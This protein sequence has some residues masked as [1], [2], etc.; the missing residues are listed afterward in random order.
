MA[1]SASTVS[2]GT[3]A[4]L[5]YSVPTTTALGSSL[6]VANTGAATVFVG[7]SGV[8]TGAGFPVN[9]GQQVSI[10]LTGGESLYG[11]VASGTV[12][13]NLLVQGK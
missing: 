1:M 10:G 11:I 12:T 13:V 6:L 7:D 9:A 8:T 4:T 3:S 2:V 5:I